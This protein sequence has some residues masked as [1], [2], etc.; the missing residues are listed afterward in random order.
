M[1]TQDKGLGSLATLAGLAKALSNPN[2]SIQS[3]APSFL[4]AMAKLT[5]TPALGQVAG[6]ANMA[7]NGVSAPGILG[8]MSAVNPA[9]G[10]LGLVNSLF[11]NP[12]GA[13][14]TAL[15]NTMS[16][17]QSMSSLNALGVSNAEQAYNA[18]NDW[19]GSM[20]T[21]TMDSLM[22]ALAADDSASF[23]GGRYDVGSTNNST[24]GN[25]RGTANTGYGNADGYGGSDGG[26]GGG[27][28]YG[29]YGGGGYDGR[30]DD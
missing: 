14:T 9:F 22:S 30:A 8:L 21:A 10:M 7:F 25:T 18:A 5:N 13:S 19:Q 17:P 4:G 28:G 12:I 26:Y 11:G 1:A 23:W 27:G 20:D 24:T 15:S 3:V 6:V 16:N 29:G 2:A